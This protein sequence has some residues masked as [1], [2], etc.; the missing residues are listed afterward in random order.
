MGNMVL[1]LMRNGRYGLIFHEKPIHHTKLNIQDS[2]KTTKAYWAHSRKEKNYIF[3]D[4][5]RNFRE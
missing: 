4:L 1:I 2:N 3:R 5:T